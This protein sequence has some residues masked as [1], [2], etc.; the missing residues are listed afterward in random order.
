MIRTTME[1]SNKQL[2]Q[3][4]AILGARQGDPESP[5]GGTLLARQRRLRADLERVDSENGMMG[6]G[7]SAI[8]APMPAAGLSSRSR[9]AIEREL[10]LVEAELAA[11]QHRIA[12][13]DGLL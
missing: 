12:E 5:L 8:V 10:D 7:V 11:A 9:A 6:H 1:R 3:E 2:L 13:I 4:R